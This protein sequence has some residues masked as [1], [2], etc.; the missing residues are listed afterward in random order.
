MIMKQSV[1]LALASVGFC[2][3]AHDMH[4]TEVRED[5]KLYEIQDWFTDM[6]Q[7]QDDLLGAS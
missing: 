2:Q 6:Y 5:L 4:T 3:D 1:L 7:V